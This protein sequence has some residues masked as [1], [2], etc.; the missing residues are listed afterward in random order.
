MKSSKLATSL[1]SGVRCVWLA[2]FNGLLARNC[3]PRVVGGHMCRR[4]FRQPMFGES[5]NPPTIQTKPLTLQLTEAQPLQKGRISLQ[6][7]NVGEFHGFCARHWLRFCCR[8]LPCSGSQRCHDLLLECHSC[9]QRLRPFGHERLSKLGALF[10][11]E[12]R[13]VPAAPGSMFDNSPCV[14][15]WA[16]LLL[17]NIFQLF[18]YCGSVVEVQ[19]HFPAQNLKKKCS[20]SPRSR[21][22]ASRVPRRSPRRRLRGGHPRSGQL[23]WTP[24]QLRGFG[25][26][27]GGRSCLGA[28]KWAAKPRPETPKRAMVGG[29]EVPPVQTMGYLGPPGALSHQLFWLGGFPY[30]NRLKKKGTLILILTS[31]LED[32]AKVCS[33]CTVLVASGRVVLL[34]WYPF[35]GGRIFQGALCEVGVFLRA[36]E[37]GV[38]GSQKENPA[39]LKGTPILKHAHP[40]RKLW[41][42]RPCRCPDSRKNIEP[43]SSNVPLGVLS[44]LSPQRTC[45]PVV[46]RGDLLSLGEFALSVR[47]LGSFI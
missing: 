19:I 15:W 38:V 42:P 2:H 12:R 40:A 28:E 8:D 23:H 30:K 35:W 25:P 9:V 24:R 44:S 26:E 20:P 43:K 39:I 5:S 7:P 27:A 11:F 47:S 3:A 29:S 1:D 37:A 32:L 34:S 46:L 16:W 36:F 14:D 31:L 10:G 6:N 4:I 18:V 13:H 41:C 22:E 45:A 33:V 17:G 21:L